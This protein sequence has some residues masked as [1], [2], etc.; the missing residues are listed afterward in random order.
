[1]YKFGQTKTIIPKNIRYNLSNQW[2]ETLEAIDIYINIFE[3]TKS[4][5]CMKGQT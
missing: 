5:F 1:M 3:V 4:R 2:S